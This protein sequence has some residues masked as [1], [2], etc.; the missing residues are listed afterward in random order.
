[1]RQQ[2]TQV[3]GKG[4][5]EADVAPPRY[6]HP[7]AQQFFGQCFE[8][9]GWGGFVHK[10]EAGL[11]CFGHDLFNPVHQRG[12]AGGFVAADVVQADI[13]KAA[14]FPITTVRHRQFVPAAIA[15]QPVHGVEHVQQRQILVQRQ[16]IPSGGAHVFKSDLGLLQ[17]DILHLARFVFNKG[18]HQALGAAPP[19]QVFNQ[20][21]QRAFTAIQSDEV[22]MVKHSGIFQFTQFGVHKAATQRNA[23]LRI[24]PLDALRD[25]KSRIHRARKR[26]RQQHQVGLVSRHGLQRQGL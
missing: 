25:A 1:M 8:C 19:L 5:F 10:M 6:L 24:R 26:H 18:A 13:A 16:A 9:F 3:R 17:V 22:H 11:A 4:F 23:N 21:E 2:F 14:F 15:P 7:P 12:G 20:I